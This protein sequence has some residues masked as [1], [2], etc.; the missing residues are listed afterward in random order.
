MRLDLPT[1]R[2]IVEAVDR[3]AGTGQW[4]VRPLQGRAGEYRLRVG[5]W[6]ILFSRDK[7]LLLILILRVRPRGDAYQFDR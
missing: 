5:E 7:A 4:D 6:R 3:F 1:Q 2:R